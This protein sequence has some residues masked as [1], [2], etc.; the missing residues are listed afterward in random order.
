M[1]T[2]NPYRNQRAE[3]V[4]KA[5]AMDFI[6][7][8]SNGTSLVTVTN[9]ILENRGKNLHILFSVLPEDKELVVLDFL[10]RKTGDF[11]DFLKKKSRIGI[12]PFVEFKIDLGEKNRQIVDR[13]I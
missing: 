7:R 12:I 5:L 1:H 13:L 3:D 10:K 8:E 9:V 2:P 6:E 4:L 11:K